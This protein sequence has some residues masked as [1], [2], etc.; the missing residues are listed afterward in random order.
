M[1]KQNRDRLD[2]D[3][4][5][6]E[7]RIGVIKN[8]STE[9]YVAAT[10]PRATIQ[11]FSGV[12]ARNRGIQA[13]VQGKID[14]II[15]DGVLLR[16]E[17]QKQGLSSSEYPLIPETPLT[18]DRYGTIV[19]SQDEEWLNFVNSVINSPEAA[20]LARAWFGN[21]SSNGLDIVVLNKNC[22]DNIYMNSL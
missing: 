20:N 15:S 17:A 10:Y 13:L 11:Q 1:R 4:N 7:A 2:L 6:N 22:L 18:C 12:T 16:A 3:D 8:T 5:L 9:E 21:Y 19:N 14:G